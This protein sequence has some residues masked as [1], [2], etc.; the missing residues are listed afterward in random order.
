MKGSRNN[1]RR[2]RVEFQVSSN[3]PDELLS[4]LLDVE[5]SPQH[6]SL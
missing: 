5:H 4:A 1:E 6:K 2:T 3:I